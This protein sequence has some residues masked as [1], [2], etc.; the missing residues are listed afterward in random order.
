MAYY[1]ID[2]RKWFTGPKITL[3]TDNLTE[4]QQ[5]ALREEGLEV[6]DAGK[7]AVIDE[8]DKEVRVGESV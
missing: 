3:D 4:E 2:A 1:Y 8:N 7:G 5:Q 6:H